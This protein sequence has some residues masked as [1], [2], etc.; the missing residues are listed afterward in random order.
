[1][2]LFDT[3]AEKAKKFV[4]S[5]LSDLHDKLSGMINLIEFVDQLKGRRTHNGKVFTW[6]LESLGRLG[7]RSRKKQHL[8]SALD[9]SDNIFDNVKKILSEI[10]VSGPGV[11]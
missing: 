11:V 10:S 4:Q 9:K 7:H 3:A 2:N 8:L 6:G 5:F 1:M